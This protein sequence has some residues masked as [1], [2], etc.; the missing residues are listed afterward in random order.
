MRTTRHI[1]SYTIRSVG[2][3]WTVTDGER[4]HG[5]FTTL[6][7]ALAWC[8]ANPHGAKIIAGDFTD[9]IRDCKK[10]SPLDCELNRAM[11]ELGWHDE[12]TDPMSE[13]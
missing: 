2:R 3:L 6:R 12:P 1:G 10:G 9:A 8:R 11:R 13:D 4:I 7:T 5:S